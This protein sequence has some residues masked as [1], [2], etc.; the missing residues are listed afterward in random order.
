MKNTNRKDFYENVENGQ[1]VTVN[2]R[3]NSYTFMNEKCMVGRSLYDMCDFM[4][5]N[6][7]QDYWDYNLECGEKG[8]IKYRREEDR[9]MNLVKIVFH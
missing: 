9:L 1:K 6:D 4:I 7:L 3:D 2:F 5:G 8:D